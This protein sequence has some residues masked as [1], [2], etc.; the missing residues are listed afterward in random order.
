MKCQWSH[1]ENYNLCIV[2]AFFRSWAGK[3]LL[4]RK[5]Q[6]R[7]Q[8]LLKKKK[9][10]KKKKKRRKHDKNNLKKIK[11]QIKQINS[12]IITKKNSNFNLK[13]IKIIKVK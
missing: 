8:R 6:V 1:M 2:S 9:E 5:N 13:K 3:Q 4:L 11:I 12:K 7:D 10:E